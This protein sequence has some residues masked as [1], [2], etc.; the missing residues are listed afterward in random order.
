MEYSRKDLIESYMVCLLPE[1][2]HCQSWVDDWRKHFEKFKNYNKSDFNKIVKT[3]VIIKPDDTKELLKLLNS[4]GY[5][6]YI[7]NARLTAQ[8][9]KQGITKS[10][11]ITKFQKKNNNLLERVKKILNK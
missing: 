8:Y 4:C 3:M 1:H 5:Q 6:L 7:M 11:E 10:A 2:T 9:Y